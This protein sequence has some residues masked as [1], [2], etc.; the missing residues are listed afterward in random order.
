MRSQAI[1]CLE[2]GAATQRTATAINTERKREVCMSRSACEI[3]MLEIVEAIIRISGLGSEIRMT[4]L[5]FEIVAA[6]SI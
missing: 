2:H 5:N 1:D 4:F 3:A 6:L